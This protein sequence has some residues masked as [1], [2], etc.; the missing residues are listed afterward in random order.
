MFNTPIAFLPPKHTLGV[1]HTFTFQFFT[2]K[3]ALIIV[4]VALLIWIMWSYFGTRSIEKPKVVSKSMLSGGVELRE[5]APMIQA[6][7][8]VTWDQSQAI[9]NWFR[10]LAWYIFGWNTVKQ[11]VAMTAPVALSKSNTSIAMTAPVALQQQ[12][13]T[14]RVSFM[15]PSKYTLDTLPK[16]TN[17]NISFAQLPS[18]KYHVWKFSWYANE[19]RAANQLAKFKKALSNQNIQTTAEP[20]LNQYNDPRTM[21]LMRTNEWWIQVQ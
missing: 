2:M 8:I 5:I 16:P 20:I 12:W 6:T 11:P 10:Q 19:S 7:V 21:P 4:G 14:Y 18:K 1:L 17:T 3:I 13:S 9:N 15:M